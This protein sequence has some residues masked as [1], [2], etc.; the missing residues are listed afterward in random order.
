MNGYC[1]QGYKQKKSPKNRRAVLGKDTSPFFF[2][3]LIY[4][5]SPLV[6]NWS[7]HKRLSVWRLLKWTQ[8]EEANTNVGQREHGSFLDRRCLC[9]SYPASILLQL[10]LAVPPVVFW[11]FEIIM[12][13]S[14]K[15]SVPEVHGSDCLYN[16]G[17]R[18]V[19]GQDR[20]H[21]FNYFSL[22]KVILGRIIH[23]R[24]HLLSQL[25]DAQRVI[26]EGVHSNFK[27]FWQSFLF[28]FNAARNRLVVE[29][30]K[31]ESKKWAA[32]QVWT[33]SWDRLSKTPL[34]F[35]WR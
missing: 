19:L 34:S 4:L 23:L 26:K 22:K 7:G 16:L 5:S 21:I 32:R 6:E 13:R 3:N 15:V 28:S 9:G 2:S 8:G 12:A 11:V 1:S 18:L 17:S 20:R 10:G 24:K 29:M 33:N 30:W 14:L 25:W 27:L 31:C 35:F